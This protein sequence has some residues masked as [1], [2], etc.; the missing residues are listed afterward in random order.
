L[1]K[2]KRILTIQTTHLG[3]SSSATL[4]EYNISLFCVEG[5]NLNKKIYKKK[6]ID[7][8]LPLITVK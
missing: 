6:F 2:Q 3:G 8:I 4:E 7:L 5:E 1:N